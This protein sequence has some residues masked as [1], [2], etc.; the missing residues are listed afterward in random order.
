[1]DLQFN[2]IYIFLLTLHKVTI[3]LVLFVFSHS[4]LRIFVNLLK[5]IGNS[6]NQADTQLLWQETYTYPINPRANTI[7]LF[8]GEL[9]DK[10]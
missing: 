6:W 10:F 2:K 4:D 3:I 5:N 1:M 7:Q 9:L 8:T